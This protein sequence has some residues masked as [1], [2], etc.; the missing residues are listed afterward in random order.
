[1]RRVEVDQLVGATEISN[2]LGLRRSTHVH[3]LR[4][5]DPIFPAPL[6]RLSSG[7]SGAYVWYWPDIEWWARRRGRVPLQPDDSAQQAA[8]FSRTEEDST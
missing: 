6:T 4:K 5:N 8:G 2:R 1:M 7:T 3:Q